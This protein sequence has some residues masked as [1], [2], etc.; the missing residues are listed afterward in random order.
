MVGGLGFGWGSRVRAWGSRMGAAG[1]R[2][3]CQR[4]RNSTAA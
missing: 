3:E 1:V 2:A 4:T